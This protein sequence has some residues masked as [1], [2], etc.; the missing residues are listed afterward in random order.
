MRA[1]TNLQTRSHL[2]RLRSKGKKQTDFMKVGRSNGGGRVCGNHAKSRGLS[3]SGISKITAALGNEQTTGNIGRWVGI[4]P[5]VR[6]EQSKDH[7]SES[8]HCGLQ[9][10]LRS[11]QRGSGLVP[12]ARRKSF[13]A[14]GLEY[15]RGTGN[16]LRNRIHPPKCPFQ[17]FARIPARSSM[18]NAKLRR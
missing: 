11:S 12:M 6:S 8:S 1:A 18:T 15:A 14:R 9:A 5:V 17:T 2:L 10:S 13:T 7:R 16:P 4:G 3:E